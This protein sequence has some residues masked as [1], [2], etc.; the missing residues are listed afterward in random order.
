MRVCRRW[1]AAA[2]AAAVLAAGAAAQEKKDDK[3]PHLDKVPKKVLDALKA[4][5][6]KA[7][8]HKLT[9]EKEG[10]KV[11]YDIE[12]TQDKRKFEADVFE[13]GTIQNW[14]REVPAK[15]LPKAVTDAV[16]KRYPKATLKEVM[17][18]FD[19]KDG[20]DT[21]GG[22]EI[23]LETAD[24]KSVEVTVTADGKITEDS[25]EKKKDK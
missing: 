18:V 21:P 8:V 17:E 25:G 5:F 23:T 14:E 1:C 19:V 9:V 2:L 13:D 16:E 6:P 15:D 7:E 4:K 20:K 10:D 3:K 12:F 22:F 24:K 11:V